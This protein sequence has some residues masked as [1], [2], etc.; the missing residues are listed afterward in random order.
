M[1]KIDGTSFTV[2][3]LQKF[4]PEEDIDAD[5]AAP[6]NA[7]ALAGTAAARFPR[8][9]LESGRVVASVKVAAAAAARPLADGHGT[10]VYFFS[11][12]HVGAISRQVGQVED[13]RGRH[14]GFGGVEELWWGKK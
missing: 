8:T 5:V 10:V 12:G 14:L 1:K 2:D 9:S 6:V 4:R 3:F 13:V 11:R 7:A